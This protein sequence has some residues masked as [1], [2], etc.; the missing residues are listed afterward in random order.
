LLNKYERK[1]H[2]I[3]YINNI[4]SSSFFL[5]V[6]LWH[7]FCRKVKYFAPTIR[8]FCPHNKNKSVAKHFEKVALIRF[9]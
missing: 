4:I 1:V 2:K 3:I 5:L 6:Y 9:F 8:K 7:R